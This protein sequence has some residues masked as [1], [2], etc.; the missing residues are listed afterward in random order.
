MPPTNPVNRCWL[1]DLRL[2]A[3][4]EGD[5]VQSVLIVVDVHFVQHAGIEGEIV[6]S[7]GGF[8]LKGST[9]RMNV[10][11]GGIVIADKG[12]PVRNIGGAVQCRNRCFA[13]T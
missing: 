11:F 5:V 10:T 7:V 8:K 2:E 13:M 3:E 1:A 4:L 6:G 12:V 9:F